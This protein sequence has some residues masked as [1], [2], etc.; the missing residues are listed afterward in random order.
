MTLLAFMLVFMCHTSY[1]LARQF[2]R[3][4]SP[5]QCY[6]SLD[7]WAKGKQQTPLLPGGIDGSTCSEQPC[8]KLTE[9]IDPSFFKALSEP[10]RLI[11]LRQLLTCGKKCPVGRLAQC[12]PVDPSVVSR[13]LR[14]LREAGLVGSERHGKEIRY[15][16]RR[17]WIVEQFST[18][19]NIVIDNRCGECHI[20]EDYCPT[21]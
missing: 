20:C 2:E 9:S 11:I 16:A 19:L 18:L 1:D 4:C 14:A 21:D 5:A 17:D 12:C 13:H 15:F 10:N 7:G 6:G 8:E 3:S